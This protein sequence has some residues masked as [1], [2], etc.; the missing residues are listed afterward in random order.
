MNNPKSTSLF[1]TKISHRKLKQ[2]IRQTFSTKAKVAV[3]KTIGL[4]FVKL[5]FGEGVV[6]CYNGHVTNGFKSTL[7][8][9]LAVF[10]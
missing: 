7:M 1:Q 9:F 2:L 6:G 5:V 8:V 10:N 4:F 3:P